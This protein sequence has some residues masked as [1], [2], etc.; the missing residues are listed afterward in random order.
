MEVIGWI[1]SF[2]F[3]ICGIPLA[4][5]SYKEKHSDGQPWLFLFLWFT[6]EIA[7]FIYTLDKE[8][9]P[10]QVNYVLNFMC[11]LIIMYYKIGY[12]KGLENE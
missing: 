10:L 3:A 4:Y 6:G 8:V 1:S 12:K 5:K 11:L 2:C 9:L 7:A